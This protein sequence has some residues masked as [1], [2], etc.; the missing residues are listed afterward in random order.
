MTDIKWPEG[1]THKIDDTFKKWVD[2]AEYFYSKENEWVKNLN[3]WSIDKYYKSNDFK[4]IERPIDAPYMPEV[5]EWCDYRTVQKGEYRKAFFIGHNEVGEHVLKDVP[6]DFIEDNCNFRPI[7]T[8]REK[9][10]KK[11]LETTSTDAA[12][13]EAHYVEIFGKMWDDGFNAPE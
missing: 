4:V 2:G 6:G 11:S 7:K 10:I 9:F 8:E 3:S 12:T 1:A 5:G 13:D